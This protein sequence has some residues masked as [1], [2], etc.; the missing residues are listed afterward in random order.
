MNRFDKAF[1]EVVGVS[2]A[3]FVTLVGSIRVF[4]ARFVFSQFVAVFLELSA[5][6]RAH[7]WQG[8]R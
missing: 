1:V 3:S 4:F 6:R 5:S 2:M 8:F 7:V